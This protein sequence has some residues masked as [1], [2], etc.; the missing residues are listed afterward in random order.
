MF[1]VI[2]GASEGEE[3]EWGGDFGAQRWVVEGVC[4]PMRIV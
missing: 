2:V 1:A 4:V 3:R